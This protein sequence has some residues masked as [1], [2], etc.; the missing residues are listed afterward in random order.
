MPD[1]DRPPRNQSWEDM[2]KQNETSCKT[3]YSVD[4]TTNLTEYALRLGR[5]YAIRV[6]KE[7]NNTYTITICARGQYKPRRRRNNG[8]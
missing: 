8:T 6:K 7:L 1:N 4:P 2:G 5:N 3:N